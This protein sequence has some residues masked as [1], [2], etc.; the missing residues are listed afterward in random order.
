MILK[1]ETNMSPE[2]KNKQ[3]IVILGTSLFAPEVFDLIEDTGGYEVTA[4]V[5][6]WDRG[7]I[8]KTLCNRPILWIEDSKNLSAT[9]QAVCSLGTTKRRLLIE[10]AVSLG[11]QFVTIIHPT[12]RISGKSTVGEGSI[13]SAGAIIGGYTTIGRHVIVNRGS[14]IGHH[15]AIHDFVTISP[16]ANIAGAVTIGESTYVGMGAII[17]DRMVIGEGSVI[18]AGSVVVKDVPDR[19][20]VMGI[21]ARISKENVEG[22]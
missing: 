7:K 9:H 1:E 4:F 18:G 19:V 12:A 20:Q 15:T 8:G 2:R 22:R 16:G 3:E 10:Q 6:N 11:F 21:P 13:V 5:E 14:L 17:L